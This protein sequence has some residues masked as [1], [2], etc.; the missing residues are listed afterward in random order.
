MILWTGKERAYLSRRSDVCS[1]DKHHRPA[2][3]SLGP[4]RGK[5]SGK[6]DLAEALSF[7]ALYEGHRDMVIVWVANV[8]G[9]GGKGK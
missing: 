5:V 1:Y 6:T 4:V 7:S 2:E 3:G 8:V 9:R